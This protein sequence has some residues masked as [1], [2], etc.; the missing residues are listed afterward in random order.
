[1][2]GHLLGGAGAVEAIFTVLAIH[3]R[4]LP[5]IINYS[6]PDPKCDLDYVPNTARDASVDVALTNGFGFGG[7]NTALVFSKFVS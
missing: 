4:K 1:M 3:E 7:T 5:A 2:T 6:M